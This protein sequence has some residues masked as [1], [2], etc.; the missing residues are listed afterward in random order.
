MAQR[1][2]NFQKLRRVS[3][4]IRAR[5]MHAVKE[6][7]DPCCLDTLWSE[8]FGDNLIPPPNPVLFAD[9]K[10]FVQ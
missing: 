2:R 9:M 3:S 7:A 1:T 4:L 5:L 8:I 10:Q 6:T